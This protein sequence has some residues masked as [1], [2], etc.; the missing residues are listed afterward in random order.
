MAGLRAAGRRHNGVWGRLLVHGL[1]P[2]GPGPRR[3]PSREGTPSPGGPSSRRPR[4]RR[5]T[6]GLGW[7]CEFG[8]PDEASP[9]ASTSEPVP[10]VSPTLSDWMIA[11][12][13]VDRGYR[14]KG[15]AAALLEGRSAGAS[16]L[17]EEPWKATRKRTPEDGSVSGPSYTAERNLDVRGVRCSA[18]VARAALGRTQRVVSQGRA[19]DSGSRWWSV[20]SRRGGCWRSSSAE[21]SSAARPRACRARSYR[22]PAPTRRLNAAG[23]ATQRRNVARLTPHSL[24]AASSVSSARS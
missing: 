8:P 2:G 15:V 12:F 13:F 24:A 14:R 1:P 7:L 4:V 5:S 6:S 22:R 18:R 23:V 3:E 9:H 20:P 10:R 17:G 11:C 21:R 16:R 19:R